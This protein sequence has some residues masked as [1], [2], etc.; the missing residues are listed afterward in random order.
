MAVK[1]QVKAILM[2]SI[3]A[4]TFTG[5]YLPINPLGLPNPCFLIRI[6]NNSNM[7]ITISYDQTIPSDAKSDADFL[8]ANE[9]LQLN[10]QTNSQ[11]S[12]WW[13]NLQQGT[14]VY[15]KGAVGTGKVYLVGYYQPTAN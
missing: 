4:T 11:P 7:P 5:A 3:D 15:V 2:T 8:P 12:N 13:A 9:E 6:I 10:F 14:I 1:N